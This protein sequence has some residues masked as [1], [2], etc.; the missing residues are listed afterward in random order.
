MARFGKIAMVLA[1]AVAAGGAF[2]QAADEAPVVV[3]Q[4]SQWEKFKTGAKVAGEAIAQGSKNTAEKVADGAHR[5]GEAVVDGSKKAGK[6]IAEGYE[7]AKEYVKE[8]VE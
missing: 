6:A 3:E 5:A 4:E 7:D 2:A 8:K 1:A